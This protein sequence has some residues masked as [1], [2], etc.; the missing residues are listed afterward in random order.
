MKWCLIQEIIKKELQQLHSHDEKSNLF[1][2]GQSFI[3][4]LFI[5]SN[6]LFCA[7]TDT[8]NYHQHICICFPFDGL[9]F[10][11]I[12]SYYVC[13]AI[14]GSSQRV[15][16]F[17]NLPIVG[18]ILYIKSIEIWNKYKCMGW[19]WWDDSSSKCPIQNIK[20]HINPSAHSF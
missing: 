18:N 8:I 11:R 2:K 4:A 7:Y 6:L 1:C 9:L 19:K 10:E 12:K 16:V 14:F 5:Q 17:S 20:M 15:T 3:V 13:K